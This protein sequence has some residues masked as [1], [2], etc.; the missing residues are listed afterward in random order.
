[1]S[2][3]MNQIPQD[4]RSKAAIAQHLQ[5]YN[6]SLT[7]CGVYN[8]G[9]KDYI[10]YD[11]RMVSNE[12]WIIPNMNR[13]IGHGKGIQHV[14]RFI[15]NRFINHKG[16]ELI[17][18]L[19]QKDWDKRKLEFPSGERGVANQNSALRTDDPNL[20]DQV[21]PILW[22]GVVERYGNNGI[23]EEMEVA[24]PAHR[25][26][27]MAEDALDRLGLTDQEIGIHV[28]EQKEQFIESIT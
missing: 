1:M 24:E 11:D 6:E 15:A 10:V 25:S 27:S 16:I 12:K 7:T 22:R 17:N 4:G 2:F 23:D 8:P 18:V 19:I 21:T 5:M 26:V 13:D 20:W 14:P 3:S 9:E 28:N